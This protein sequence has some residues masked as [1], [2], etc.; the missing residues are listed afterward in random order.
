MSSADACV[1][2][3]STIPN[4]NEQQIL[5]DVEACFTSFKSFV[6]LMHNF[7]HYDRPLL[8]CSIQLIPKGLSCLVKYEKKNIFFVVLTKDKGIG[9]LF[10]FYVNFSCKTLRNTILYTTPRLAASLSP[11]T[12]GGNVAEWSARRTQPTGVASRQLILFV[13]KYLSGVPVN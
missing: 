11:G 8:V 6:G 2:S 1:Y 4:I 9:L 7:T 5:N 10:A 13:S 3:H 12:G